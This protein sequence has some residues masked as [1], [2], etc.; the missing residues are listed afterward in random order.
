MNL[1]RI[2]FSVIRWPF[3]GNV[4]TDLTW[5]LFLSEAKIRSLAEGEGERQS[6][7]AD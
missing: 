3:H 2:F 5:D 4:L 6:R 7:D 1:I